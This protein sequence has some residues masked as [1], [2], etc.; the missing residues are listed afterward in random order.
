[1][2]ALTLLSLLLVAHVAPIGQPAPQLGTTTIRNDSLI[3]GLVDDVGRRGAKAALI[4][5]VAAP[6]LV[7]LV[8][9]SATPRHLALALAGAYQR[10]PSRSSEPY[11]EARAW[12]TDDTRVGVEP[13]S[14]QLRLAAALLERLR[15]A[16]FQPVRG[17]GRVK[18]IALY[19]PLPMS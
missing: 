16:R 5:R 7:V 19:P 17:I 10:P 14:R 9:S 15:V 12:I 6:H 3:V 2:H 18:A 4:R 8:S 11:T 1:M 13:G